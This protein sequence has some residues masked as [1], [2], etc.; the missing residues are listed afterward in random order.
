[1]DVTWLTS[2]GKRF[3]CEVKLSEQE[4]G[5]AADD[6][7]HRRKLAE[8]Y[9][10]VLRD[11][12]SDHLLEGAVFFKQYQIMRNVWHAARDTTSE[13]LFLLPKA[14]KRL[15]EPLAAVRQ[16]ISPALQARIR[17]ASIED[18]LSALTINGDLPAR[19]VHHA[20]AL[21]EKYVIHH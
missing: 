6:E 4:F 19:L 14:N 5:T 17:V 15:W 21:Q 3:F 7:R 1:V 18:T 2:E 12:C 10:P 13:V 20:R 9:S 16:A 8:I 11:H